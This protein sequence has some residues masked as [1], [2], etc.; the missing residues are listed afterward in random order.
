MDMNSPK[1]TLVKIKNH[2]NTNKVAYVAGTVAVM[3]IALQQRNRLEFN[4]FLTEKGIDPEEY[5]CPE[6]YEEKNQ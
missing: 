3:A 1:K 4:K 2:L 6:S 5:Y